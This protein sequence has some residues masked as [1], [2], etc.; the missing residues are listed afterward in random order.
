MKKY[1][2]T[3]IQEIIEKHGK[4]DTGKNVSSFEN[5]REFMV[6]A[7]KFSVVLAA[8]G[9][10]TAGLAK[11]LSAAA[12]TPTQ[13]LVKH[14]VE[15][16]NMEEAIRMYGAQSKLNTK[17]LNALRTLTRSDLETLRIIKEKLAP[18]GNGKAVLWIA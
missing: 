6:V 5:R 2:D 16:G 17:Q 1:P 8:L 7:S 11:N 13:K 15:T 4:Q 10:S 9:L 12:L 3:D 14:A 18:L